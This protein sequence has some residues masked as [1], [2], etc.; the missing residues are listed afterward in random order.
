MHILDNFNV[1]LGQPIRAIQV[2]KGGI[3]ES[4]GGQWLHVVDSSGKFAVKRTI[5]T[6]RMNPRFYE[7]LV[8]LK[9]GEKV[10]VS[11]YTI[12]SKYDLIIRSKILNL[13]IDKPIT[14]DQ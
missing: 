11:S 13:F 8:D 6:G 2:M 7:I 9:P 12:Q 4:T 5:R 1:E 10:V 14:L 3:L